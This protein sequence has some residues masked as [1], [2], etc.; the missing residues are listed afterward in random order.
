MYY[1]LHTLLDRI[2]ALNSNG[3]EFYYYYKRGKDPASK[4]IPRTFVNF[5]LQ[6]TKNNSFTSSSFLLI[7]LNGGHN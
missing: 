5:V 4:D 3:N 2:V 1:A 6:E 7:V